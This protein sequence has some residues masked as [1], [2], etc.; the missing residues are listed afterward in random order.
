MDA[1]VRFALWRLTLY[2]ELGLKIGTAVMLV[3][4]TVGFVTKV[5]CREK[6]RVS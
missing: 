3:D 5:I 6:A 1:W 4:L 2:E